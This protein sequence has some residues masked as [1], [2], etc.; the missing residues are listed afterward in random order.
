MQTGYPQAQVVAP[1]PGDAAQQLT[2]AGRPCQFPFFYRGEARTQC[3]PYSS[4]DSSAFCLDVDGR[5]S[6]CSPTL[7]T[8]YSAFVNWMDQWA[9][10]SQLQTEVRIPHRPSSM[11]SAITARA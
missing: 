11:I 1:A 7:T 3:V 2:I 8:D 5:F 6:M 10:M 4:S 9:G